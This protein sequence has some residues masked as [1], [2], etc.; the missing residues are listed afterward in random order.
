MRCSGKRVP[1]PGGLPLE[2]IAIGSASSA[3]GLFVLVFDKGIS[4]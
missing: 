2:S 3:A 1:Q 4:M